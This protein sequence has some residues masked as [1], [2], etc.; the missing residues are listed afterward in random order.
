MQFYRYKI[1]VEYSGTNYYGLQIQQN[2]ALPT[3]EGAI[4]KALQQLTNYNLLDLAV[5]GRTDAGV[6]ALGQVFHFDATKFLQN[7]QVVLGLNHYLQA[8][9]IRIVS[10]CLVDE[11]FHAR[12]SAKKRTYQYLI[13]NRKVPSP[14][15]KNLA[16]HIAKPLD[17]LAMKKAS[18]FLIGC[19][20]FSAFRDGECQAKSPI[21][22]LDAIDFILPNSTY[23]FNNNGLLID[24]LKINVVAKSFLHHMVR[25]II[26]TLVYVGLGKFQSTDVLQ[27]LQS[28]N[29]SKAGPTAPACGLYF[30][31]VDF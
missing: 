22:S 21:R 29:R 1:V 19:H 8:E 25:N 13:Y 10:A 16:W 27:I 6:H 30:L 2:P 3:I 4:V 20:N 11:N 18:E 12:F 23:D 15:L 5:A 17:I 14:L 9:D 24:I 31:S 7:H 26:G 28:Q